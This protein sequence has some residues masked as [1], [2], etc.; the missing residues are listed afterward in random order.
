MEQMKAALLARIR[1]APGTGTEAIGKA[2]AIP[3]RDLALPVRKLSPRRRSGATVRNARR[4]SS[5]PDPRVSLRLPS[6]GLLP[7]PRLPAWFRLG[8][9]K[10][11]S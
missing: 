1:K 3:K 10:G 7:L 5:P 11:P 2:I 6:G 8:P 9:M 4:N